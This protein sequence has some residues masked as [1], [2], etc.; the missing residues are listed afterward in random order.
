MSTTHT[1][2]AYAPRGAGLLAAVFYFETQH[3]VYGW[4]GGTRDG[5]FSSAFFMLADFFTQEPTR[6]YLTQGTDIYGG[7]SL[8]ASAGA[9]KALEAP[10]PADET[11][12]VELD[13]LQGA[14]WTEWLIAEDEHGAAPE[15]AAYEARGLPFMHVNIKS[16]R[17]DRL[18]CHGPVW[19]YRSPGA[20][21]TV[22]GGLTAHW[23]L[24]YPTR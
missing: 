18:E 4:F 1:W 9:V 16:H 8:R 2:I 22:L 24:D 21:A 11:L 17:L 23:P 10:I 13:R 3:H 15:R 6:L 5:E 19:Q 7:W 14:F 12:C 20:D